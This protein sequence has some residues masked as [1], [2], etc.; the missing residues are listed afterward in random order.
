M[1][2]TLLRYRWWRPRPFR[3]C[4]LVT[5]LK[6]GSTLASLFALL[7]KVAGVYGLIAL[8]TGAGG[9][10]AQL[11]LY[12]YSTATLVLFAWG[13]RALQNEDPKRALYFAHM[14][15]ADHLFSSVWTVF[16]GVRWW[17]VNP[18]DGRRQANSAAQEDM[19]RN[20]NITHLTDEERAAAA[21]T[22]W[23][24]EKG[25]A[26]TLL[27]LGWVVKVCYVFN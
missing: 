8:L 21:M 23:N 9:S 5:D 14:Y 3:S 17:V 6:T 7:N 1:R 18:H 16:F 25:F 4:L 20:A 12:V 26:L 13:L 10:L 2:L 15:F 27:I 19:M 22:I 24:Q 11:S